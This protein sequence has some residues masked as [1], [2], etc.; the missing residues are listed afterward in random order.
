MK[1]GP[2]FN[3]SLCSE[4]NA[5]KNDV[6]VLWNIFVTSNCLSHN[7]IFTKGLRSASFSWKFSIQICTFM[8]MCTKNNL[9]SMFFQI[10]LKL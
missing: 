2:H 10:D 6:I 4:I 8:Y 7:L 3:L 1:G 5:N 9:P